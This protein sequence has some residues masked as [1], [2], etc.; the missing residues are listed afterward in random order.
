MQI[1]ILYPFFPNRFRMSRNN[2]DK[3]NLGLRLKS[4]SRVF[5]VVLPKKHKTTA[6]EMHQSPDIKK[7]GP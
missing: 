3:G 2:G 5:H 1:F 7:N 6:I 4:K